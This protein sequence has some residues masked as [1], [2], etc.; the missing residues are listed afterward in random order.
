MEHKTTSNKDGVLCDRIH[1]AACKHKTWSR[2]A[3]EGVIMP[4]V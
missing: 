4:W 1:H 2:G 3:E